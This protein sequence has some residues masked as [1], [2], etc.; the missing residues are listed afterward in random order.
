MRARDLAED[1]PPVTLGTDALAAARLP[2]ERRLPGLL[3]MDGDGAPLAVL[4]A[5]RLVKSIVPAYVQEDPAL[6]A[7]VDE[8][9]A[10]RVCRP[11]AG[12]TVAADCLPGEP[13]APPIA[14]ADDT[15]LEVAALM[16][17]ERSPLVAVVEC[18]AHK[19]TRPLGVITAA[20]LL[21]RLLGET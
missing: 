18:D 14:D 3:V 20:R 6:A 12:R 4:P 1:F 19:A 8:P 7:V 13:Q 5:S 21:D 15:A 2:A 17:R 10:D 9:P 16:A 11:L